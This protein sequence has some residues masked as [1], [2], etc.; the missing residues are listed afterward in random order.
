[1]K[2][3][4]ADP[5]G[6]QQ[7]IASTYFNL[8]FGMG[9]IAALLPGGLWVGGALGDHEPLRCSMSAYYYSPTMRDPFV[10]ALVALGAF[11]YLYKGFSTKENWALN[12]AGALAIGIA[13][14]PTA[15]KCGVRSEG[16][17]V[18]AAFAVLFFLSIAY[19]CLFR[20]ADTL[21]L[22]RD[23]RKAAKFRATYRLLGVG[24]VISPLVAVALTLVLQQ[25]TEA[26][27]TVFGAEASGVLMFA[28]FWVVK[29]LELRATDADRL[30]IERKLQAVS[31]P[32]S[33]LRTPGRLIQIEE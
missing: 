28:A 5:G 18:H 24:M 14:V 22:I 8:R 29:S 1:M 30:A 27:A 17:T 15:S 12:L 9:V 4:E 33:A 25:A 20:A 2:A 11:L 21:T 31:G 7:H 3:A 16:I 32:T 23:T 6:L 19:V 10:G 13:M 26:R